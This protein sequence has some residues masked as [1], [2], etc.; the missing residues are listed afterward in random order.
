MQTGG[1]SIYLE[2][3]KNG[4]RIDSVY[5]DATG[6]NIVQSVS[7]NW[8]LELNKGQEVWIRTGNAGE[9]HGFCYTSFSGFLITQLV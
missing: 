1:H 9:I 5:V 8:V 2:L 3:M 4:V 6:L 7:E